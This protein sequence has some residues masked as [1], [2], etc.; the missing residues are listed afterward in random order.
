M[1]APDARPERRERPERAD[2]APDQHH[3]PPLDA[4]LAAVEGIDAQAAQRAVGGRMPLLEKMLRKFVEHYGGSAWSL[5]TPTH[6]DHLP[7]LQAHCHALR[8]AC[9]AIGANALAD[10]LQ[11]LE[12]AAMVPAGRLDELAGATARV[13]QDLQRLLE[14]LTRV[15]DR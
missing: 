10:A 9:A 5:A 1:N 7:A 4:L 11:D 13:R 6:V 2:A 3:A 12:R 8:G 15:L 14:G